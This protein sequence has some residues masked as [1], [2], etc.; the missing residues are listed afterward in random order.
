MDFV[1]ILKKNLRTALEA[2]IKVGKGILRSQG[3][4]SSGALEDSLEAVI[5]T[6]G[7]KIIGTIQGLD[8]GQA[9]DTGVPARNVRYNPE[10][11]RDWAERLFPSKTFR[12]ITSFIYATRRKHGQDG[13]PTKSWLARGKRLGW[14]KEMV[15]TSEAKFQ[16]LLDIRTVLENAILQSVR[17]FERG[18]VLNSSS[19]A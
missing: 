15:T 17:E 14:I 2:R 3:H 4:Y 18:G 5:Q 10:V 11:L 8:Y 9:L 6:V 12:E 1:E 16:E 19:A 7:N 13:I